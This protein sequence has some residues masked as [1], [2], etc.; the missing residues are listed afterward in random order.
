MRFAR[1]WAEAVG[2]RRTAVR[3]VYT[4]YLQSR[5]RVAPCQRKE[6]CRCMVPPNGRTRGLTESLSRKSIRDDRKSI[7]DDRKSIRDDRKSL[8]QVCGG[9][10]CTTAPR[11]SIFSICSCTCTCAASAT[12]AHAKQ[13]SIS[14]ETDC[15]ERVRI[16]L[17]RRAA[18]PGPCSA[19][20]PPVNIERP[21]QNHRR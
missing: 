5:V 14:R 21:G 20:P 19:N 6:R 12:I 10:N 15:N 13:G 11:F 16:Q 18:P 7:R 9:H 4:A 1:A 3:A 17:E 2:S 8:L